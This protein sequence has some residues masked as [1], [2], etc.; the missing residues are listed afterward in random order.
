MS[1]RAAIV[2]R[3][4][5]LAA[6]LVAVACS[7]AAG[8]DRGTIPNLATTAGGVTLDQ[9]NGT[10]GS[11]PTTMLG[12]GFN[13]TNPHRGD[14]IVVTFF[15]LG[16]TNVIT[17][18]R[19]QLTNGT[20]V[21][22]TY[23]LV[24]YV[25][26]NGISMATYVATNVQNFPDPNVDQN[27]VLVVLADLST[28]V[29][30]GGTEITA[31]SGVEAVTAQALGEHRSASGSGSGVTIA[32]PGAINA[33][34]GA[35]VYGVSLVDAL[36]GFDPPPPPFA[37]I[38]TLGAGTGTMKSDGEYAV[39]ASAGAINPQWG[40]HF[41][42]AQN[43]PRTW[44]ATAIA[45]NAGGGGGTN[46]PPTAAFTSS[47]SALS[48]GFTSTSSDPD[49]TIAAYAWNFGDGTTSTAQNPSHTYGAAGSYTVTLTV[50]DNQGA[51]GTVSHSVTVSQ[52]NQSP[53]AAFT[54]SC[55]NLT[56]SF[57]ST[58]SDPDGS[59]TAYAWAFGDGATS[60]AQN[61]SHTYGAG[62]SYT[63]TLTVTDNQG[64]TGSVS[65]SVSVS[66]ANQS[67]VAAFTS[68]CNN[69]TCSFTST[70][71]D[72]DGSI[73]AYAWAF[74]DGATS[75]AQNPSHTYG[76]GGS[77]TVTLTVTD[78]QGATGS[79]SHTVTVSQPNQPPVASFNASCSGLSCNFTSTSSDPDGSIVAYSW[80]F[81]DGGSSSAQN[82]SH[83]YGAGGTYTVTL[84]VTDNQGASSSTSRT[85]TVSQPNRPPTVNAGADESVLLGLL[86][87]LKSASFADPDNDGPWS[88][89]IDWGDGTST[90]GS[91][92]SQGGIPSATH[93]Y[94]LGTFT[95]RVT[96]TDSHG[97]SASDTKVLKVL[98]GL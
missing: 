49:G 36:V 35:L 85:V 68:S 26:A 37:N 16:S 88:Y 39:P 81:G 87:T 45:L 3:T 28:Q 51:T 73:A 58:S 83:S 41:E 8:P 65:H 27:D 64:A 17:R 2:S 56:C 63:V 38:L 93:T 5:V 24:E 94:L 66:Q 44:L 62:G 34:G 52:G 82:P 29:P 91:T 75:S 20:P 13:P 61:P 4:I 80:N 33:N 97:A 7:D 84:R 6:A 53:V 70:S 50:T 10:L 98:L 71:S 18:V 15:W 14:A 1:Q 89:R 86:Y 90:T 60:G 48:C 96:V 79:T 11:S 30:D 47:C 9:R 19:D 57:T 78:N 92:S 12:K 42:Q 77:Y 43:P 31:F 55:N 40:W 76:A 95:I 22:N 32:A 72:P 54:S 23:T 74:G 59:I 21:G 25:T 67:P 46:Q 69:L